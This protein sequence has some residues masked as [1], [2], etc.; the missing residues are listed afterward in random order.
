MNENNLMHLDDLLLTD[1]LVCAYLR[2]HPD[3]FLRQ[4]D[5]LANLRLHDQ[6]RGVVSLVERQQQTLRAKNHQLQE[7]I[8]QLMTIANHNEQLFGLYSD[9]YLRLFDCNSVPEILDCLSQTTIEL[10]SLANFKVWLSAEHTIAHHSIIHV[11]CQGVVNNRLANENFYFGRLQQS[12]QQRLFN[13]IG[14]GS[15]ILIKLMHQQ[16]VLG[17]IAISS[18]DDQHFE[19][20]MDTLLIS[21]FS[22]LVAKLLHQQ[23]A[24]G[25]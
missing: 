6:Q 23:L 9:L 7:E 2:E 19:P 5:L 1:E 15:V 11:D 8:T 24:T 18:D 25:K 22:Q 21:Q 16:Q 10:L 14:V 12:E 4:P 13:Q 17:L 20:H 3:F